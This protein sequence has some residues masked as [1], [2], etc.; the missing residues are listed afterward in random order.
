MMSAF[1]DTC[2][3]AEMVKLTEC[4]TSPADFYLF[5][6]EKVWAVCLFGFFNTPWVAESM[7]TSKRSEIKLNSM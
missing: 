6:L 5:I 7:Y 2:R 3:R 1:G 4:K